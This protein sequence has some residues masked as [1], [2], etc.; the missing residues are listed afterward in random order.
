MSNEWNSRE[1]K[2]LITLYAETGRLSSVQVTRLRGLVEAGHV[3]VALTTLL[4]LGN[5]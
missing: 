3:D 5:R 2:R 4:R 1:T